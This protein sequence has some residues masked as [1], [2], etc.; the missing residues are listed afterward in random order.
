MLAGQDE[1][2]VDDLM[3]AAAVARNPDELARA[4]LAAARVPWRHGD[5]G[6]ALGVLRAALGLLPSDARLARAHVEREIG[7]VLL[8]LEGPD[9]ADPLLTSSLQAFHDADD[10]VGRMRSLAAVAVLLAA[11]GRRRASISLLEQALAL[12]RDLR[13]PGFETTCRLRLARSLA[14]DGQ[15]ALAREQADR[16]LELSRLSADRYD[17]A[18]ACAEAADVEDKA[19]RPDAAAAL[20]HEQLR[21]L[22]AIGGNVHDQA[23]AHV[24]LAL[25]ERERGDLES[26]AWDAASAR[27]LAAASTVAADAARVEQALHA[28]PWAEASGA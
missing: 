5:L 14:G 18:T 11:T 16:A 2:G 3:R 1:P 22:A 25:I 12:A 9:A 26:A 23:W 24:H 21:L 6:A 10:P 4:Y 13:D 17:E 20:R 19:G 28:R 8:R 15:L 27:R 7:L